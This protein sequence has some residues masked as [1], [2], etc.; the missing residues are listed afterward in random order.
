MFITELDIPSDWTDA[1]A[2]LFNDTDTYTI[3]NTSPDIIYA[4]EGDS[5]P[6]S[7]LR[8][9]PVAPGNYIK[10]QKGEN[11]NLYLRNGYSP[12]KADGVD[13]QPK[14]SRVVINKVG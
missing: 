5:V 14:T 10:Y 11:A 13:T 7:K 3:V 6:A 2:K 9:I 12:V 1:A 4:L 8:G